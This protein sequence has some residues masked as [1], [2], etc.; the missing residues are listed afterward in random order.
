MTTNNAAKRRRKGEGSV[1]RKHHAS[2]G[3]PDLDAEGNRP[4]HTCTAPYRA[5]VWVHTTT[6]GRARK[7]VY[8]RTEAEVL[9]KVKALNVAEAKG[10]VTRA[11]GMTVEQW[12]T[13]WFEEA[14]AP[15]DGKPGLKLN[16]QVSYEGVMRRYL[17]PH[18]GHRQLDRLTP[19]HLATMYRRLR[20]QGLAEPTIRQGHAILRRSLVVA[21][22]A[23]LV[24]RNVAD[25]VEPPK[26]RSVN[27]KRRTPMPAEDAAKVLR[28]AGENPRFWVALLTGLRQGECLGLRWADLH[29]D[30]PEGEWPYLVVRQAMT[31][32]RG[33]DAERIGVASGVYF[34]TPKSQQ[35]TDR[36]VPLIAPVADRL[37]VARDRAYA[38]GATPQD[39]V[40]TN[41][42]GKPLDPRRDHDRWLALLGAAGVEEHYSL[43]QA[44]NTTAGLLELARVPDRVVAAIL[45]HSQVSMTH[46]YQAG[47]RASLGQAAEAL[48]GLVL[49]LEPS[50][51][52][53]DAQIGA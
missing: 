24:G 36:E 13:Q 46:H 3:C 6:G 9:K 4:D 5:R 11:S 49:A 53:G 45:G 17:I 34:D 20:E 44:R 19:Q 16:T 21:M 31:V 10:E 15:R 22:R 35:S 26:A 8:G 2:H 7:E 18:L 52:P 42:K 25:L 1:S 40:F 39:L 43:H 37:R 23:G 14:K 41:A 30:V 38:K 28:A 29:L 12:L 48:S 33:K 47:N 50:E 32:V 27:S 51:D